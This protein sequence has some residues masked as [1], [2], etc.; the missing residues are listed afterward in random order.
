ME[1]LR[2]YGHYYKMVKGYGG[3]P[4]EVTVIGIDGD[5]VTIIYGHYTREDLKYWDGLIK[6][7]CNKQKIITRVTEKQRK[8]I[9]KENAKLQRIIDEA[10]EALQKFKNGQL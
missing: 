3:I 2:L 9:D 6:M 1:E 8:Q 4:R 5:M 10:D 7:R